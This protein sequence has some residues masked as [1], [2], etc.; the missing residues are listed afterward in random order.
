MLLNGAYLLVVKMETDTGLE[1]SGK[2]AI[3]HVITFFPFLLKRM[4]CGVVV[5]SKDREMIAI[6]YLRHFLLA[7]K[8]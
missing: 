3:R 8:F 2:M 1:L 7:L 6:Q 5:H 4:T